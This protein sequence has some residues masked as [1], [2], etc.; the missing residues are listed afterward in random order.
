MK[1]K[2]SMQSIADRLN[3]SKN[4]VSQALTGKPGV[5]EETRK[6]VLATANEMGYEYPNRRK[7]RE[8]ASKNIALIASEFAFSQKGFFGEI[9]LSVEKELL[10]KG[11]NL[12]I[13]SITPF[14][15]DHLIL[16]PFIENRTVDG[17]LILSHISNEYIQKIIHTGIPTVL[18]DHHDPALTADAI[19]TNNRFAAFNA[20]KYLHELGHTSIAFVG[21]TSFSPSYLER[22]EGY[23]MAFKK[24]GLEAKDEWMITSIKETPE[25]VEAAINA[26]ADLPTAWFC[27]NDGLGFYVM[28]NLQKKGLQVPEDASVCNFDNGQLSKIANPRITT[29]DIDL[30]FYGKK[31]LQQ[32]LWR[33]ENPE[34]PH[35]EILLPAKLVKRE[36]TGAV[37]R[38]QQKRQI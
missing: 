30:E 26:L 25:E 15:R 1:S 2:V 21:D 28:S 37:P 4:S 7:Q 38:I 32:L 6:L 36:S 35:Q 20:I 13:Q 19:L 29:M 22:L 16:P 31:G 24:L 23:L 5:S 12:T 18:I 3:I 8:T 9:Y 27:V 14:A 34:E 33:L 10:S 17:V 11:M